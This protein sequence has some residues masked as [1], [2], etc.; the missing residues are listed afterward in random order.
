[1]WSTEHEK[2]YLMHHGILGMKWGVRRY[3]NEDGTLTAAGK[4]RYDT[5]T[6]GDMKAFA[7]EKGMDTS[8]KGSLRSVS[9]AYKKELKE[10]RKE[11]AMARSKATRENISKIVKSP[12]AKAAVGIGLAAIGSY[13]L[14]TKSDTVKSTVNSL[15]KA[16][17]LSVENFINGNGR[18]FVIIDGGVFFN[19]K[20]S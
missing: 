11:R 19:P 17:K 4:K 2:D 9:K 16:G 13:A 3:Q 7:K 5:G 18:N 20:R 1:M 6:A 10:Q 14:Y 8:S 12:K 15:A